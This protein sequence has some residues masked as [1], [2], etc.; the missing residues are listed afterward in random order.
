MNDICIV[1]LVRACNGMGPFERFIESYRSNPGGI[2]H[3]LLVVFKG[4][5]LQ[6]ELEPYLLHLGTM[7][8]QTL[9]ISDEGLDITAYRAAVIACAGQY[10]YFCFLNSNSVLLDR[11]W[12]LKLYK[13]LTVPGVGMV[14]ATGSWQSHCGHGFLRTLPTIA[15]Y[16]LRLHKGRYIG[17]YTAGWLLTGMAETWKVL[18]FLVKFDRYP[19][20][21]LRTNAFMISEALI[22]KLHWPHVLNKQEAYVFESGKR[23]INRQI[24]DMGLKLIVVGRDGAGYEKERW[25]MSN[26]FRHSK[27]ENLLVAD[28]QTLDYENGTLQWRQHLLSI[29]WGENS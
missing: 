16:N 5:Q 1:H 21:H 8:Y 3:D 27:Q 11:S 24:L 2:E 26:T 19:N 7:Q 18:L 12:L 17:R 9:E 14:A 10:R 13:C 4:F 28:N 23:G 15:I 6:K 22:R 25:N 20:Y 29:T